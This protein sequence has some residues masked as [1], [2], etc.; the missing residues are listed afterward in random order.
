MKKKKGF[1]LIEL[2]VVIAIMGIVFAMVYQNFFYQEKGMR[3]QRQISEV[4]MKARKATNYMVNEFRQIGF[5]GRG[6]SPSDHFG[7]VNGTVNS[8]VYTHDLRG[9]LSGV[10]ENPADIHSVSTR[11]DTL[12]I[13]GDRALLF[14]D[15]LGFTYFDVQ[16]NK[17][18]P[19]VFEVNSIGDWLLPKGVP[20]IGRIELTLRLVYPYSKNTVTYSE[21]AALRNLR[22]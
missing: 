15:S 18:V 17:I 7:I 6:L 3:R 13:D 8:I 16:G 9:S 4:N 21:S 22:P 19:P 2:L 20:S 1:T 12:F 10:V 14:V 11:G 5:S